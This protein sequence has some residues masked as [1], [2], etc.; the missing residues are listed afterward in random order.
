[1][2]QD[3]RYNDLVCLIK[4]RQ[5]G[6]ICSEAFPACSVAIGEAL[7]YIPGTLMQAETLLSLSIG[8][9]AVTPHAP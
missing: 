3:Q 4:S 8:S 9:E 1:M 5:I 6:W 7:R 2:K